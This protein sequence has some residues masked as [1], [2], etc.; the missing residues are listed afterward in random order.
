ML[1]S[2]NCGL[3]TNCCS[4][5]RWVICN[6]LLHEIFLDPKTTRGTCGWRNVSAPNDR[7]FPW[8]VLI[9]A[10]NYCECGGTLIA[11]G[12]LVTSTLC[13]SRV[14][15]SSILVKNFKVKVSFENY[16]FHFCGLIIHP[17]STK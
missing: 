11:P 7:Q 2:F 17:L 16:K 5:A 3:S 14:W 4:A 15:L 1:N 8:H 10:R 6:L 9:I 12:L 13:L